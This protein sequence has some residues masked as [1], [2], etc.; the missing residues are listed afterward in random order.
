MQK[1]VSGAQVLARCLS[2][3]GIKF[4]FTVPTPRLEPLI[5][6]LESQKDVRVITTHNETAAGLMA[7]GYIRR[8][9]RQAAVLT[10][11]KGRAISQI[12][13]VTNAWADKIP[14]VSLSLCEDDEPDTNKT[15]ERWLMISVPRFKR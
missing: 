9:R 6:A 10:D 7:E 11:A 5:K 2:S 1:D 15:V 8:S 14:L 4:F 12:C 3:Q 13:G